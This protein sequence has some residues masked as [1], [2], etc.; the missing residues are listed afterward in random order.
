MRHAHHDD[1]AAARQI[2]RRLIIGRD[3]THVTITA[4][5]PRPIFFM[6]S[7]YGRLAVAKTPSVAPKLLAISSFSSVMSTATIR[8][9]PAIRAPWMAFKPTPPAPITTTS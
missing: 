7:R 9:A 3:G 5:A 1:L 6:A 2:K 4:S 8:R